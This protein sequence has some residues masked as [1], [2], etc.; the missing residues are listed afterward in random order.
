MKIVMERAGFTD[1]AVDRISTILYYDSDDQALTAAFVGG[2]VAMAYSRFDA[3]TRD[4]AHADYLAS[5]APFRK[6]GGYEIP[7]EF[8][9]VCGR[10]ASG[11][12]I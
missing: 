9:V 7:G 5:I 6:D 11:R 8:V 12:S 3:A 1:V 4:A 2:P 10:K